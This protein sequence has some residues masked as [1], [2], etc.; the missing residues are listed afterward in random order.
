MLYNGKCLTSPTAYL[1]IRKVLFDND[2]DVPLKYYFGKFVKL[3]SI[4]SAF[5]NL[6]LGE[7]DAV[8]S[9]N[10]LE[11]VYLPTQKEF[12]EITSLICS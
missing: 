6:I 2:I 8:E 9:Y 7:I 12:K 5:Q 4:E 1:T 11:M 10:D 3:A